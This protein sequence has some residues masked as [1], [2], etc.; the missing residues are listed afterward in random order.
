MTDIENRPIKILVVDTPKNLSDALNLQLEAGYQPLNVFSFQTLEK[1]A[2]GTPVLV[3]KLSAV[4]VNMDV[5][6]KTPI[7]SPTETPKAP[8]VV[9]SSTPL[10]N[11]QDP[12]L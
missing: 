8:A 6:E 2:D 4:L 11:K 10:V 7:E 12:T 9:D 1:K 3:T 5:I